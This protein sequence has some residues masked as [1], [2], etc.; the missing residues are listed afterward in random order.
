MDS[1]LEGKASAKRPR[2][3]ENE[4]HEIY[5]TFKK[6]VYAQT[7]A[8]FEEAKEFLLNDIGTQHPNINML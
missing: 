4:R 3:S 8:E 1:E 2:P 6:A 7:E 5:D